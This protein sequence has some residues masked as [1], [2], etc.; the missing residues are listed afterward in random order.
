MTIYLY[1][2]THNKTGLKYLGK[3]KSKNPHRYPG[4]GTYWR[5]HLEENGYTYSTTI[6]KEC[7]HPAMVRFW[8]EYYSKLWNVVESSEWANAI[9]ETGGGPGAKKGEPKKPE[10]IKKM[11]EKRKSKGN[12][13]P[14][15][16][17]KKGLQVSWNKG[18]TKETDERLQSIGKSIS[19]SKKGKCSEKVLEALKRR[20]ENGFVPWNKGKTKNSAD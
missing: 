15:N 11:V 20:N 5:Q 17:G 6:L 3:T 12:Y 16:K 2:K 7:Q 9:P 13:T 1:V 19:Q 14:W 18:L 8:G 10:A 4:S